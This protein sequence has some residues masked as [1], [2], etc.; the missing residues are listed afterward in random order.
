MVFMDACVVAPALLLRLV[1][2]AAFLP[3]MG[4]PGPSRVLQ[5]LP[6]QGSG[7]THKR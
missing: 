5:I 7:N 1:D 3:A 6:G 2:A 4:F